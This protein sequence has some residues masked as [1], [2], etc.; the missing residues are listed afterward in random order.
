MVADNEAAPQE[1]YVNRGNPAYTKLLAQS[2]A[3]QRI[4]FLLNQIKPGMR[5]LDAGC[6]PGGI[7]TGLAQAVAPDGDV[8]GVDFDPEAL[9]AARELAAE[10]GVTNVR[11]Q[12][13][14][15]YTLPF[16]DAAFD[17]A[18]AIAVLF[19][20]HDPVAALRELRRVLKP[21]GI[22]CVSS[23]ASP[24]G[25]YPLTLLLRH[26]RELSERTYQ[27]TGIDLEFGPRQR[28]VMLAAGFRDPETR[29]TVDSYGTPRRT[30]ASAA[31]TRP[32][33]SRS[34]RVGR[35]KRR[36]RRSAPNWPPGASDPTPSPA[37]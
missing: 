32:A 2:T 1:R 23:L 7:A 24:V 34:A 6:G 9:A 36:C 11:F 27:A 17:A 10:R 8:V 26:W 28:E 29:A 3:E 25:M 35:R 4:P 13:A 31:R 22:V 20:L 18:Y 21:G 5:V 14:S 30:R 37:R 19:H 12:E 33:A 15:V 16:P